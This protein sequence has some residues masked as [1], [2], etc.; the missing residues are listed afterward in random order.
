MRVPASKYEATG[1]AKKQLLRL[2]IHENQRVYSDRFVDD[3]DKNAFNEIL[4]EVLSLDQAQ[5]LDEI[6]TDEDSTARPK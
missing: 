3:H 4:R 2:W 1:D 6:L 5:N